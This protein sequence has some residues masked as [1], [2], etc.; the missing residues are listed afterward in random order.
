MTDSYRTLAAHI[1][2][3]PDKTKG[4]RHVAN[5]FPVTD[6]QQ[7]DEA[8]QSARAR[9]PDANHHAFAWRLGRGANDFRYSDDG[10]P[11]GSAGRPMLQQL[12]GRELTDVLAVVSRYFGGTKLGTGGLVRAYGG[13][14]K[15]ALELAE[16][17]EVVPH[18]T[19]RIRHA[20]EDSGAL[21]SVCNQFDVQPTASD[22]GADVTVELSLPQVRADEFA[23]AV[24]DATA[25]RA[26]VEVTDSDRASPLRSPGRGRSAP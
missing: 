21:A 18:A 19:I 14:V 10:E 23:R 26:R 5:L 1:E 24:R 20:Y 13:A 25:A 2:H 17:V 16:I 11:S 22:Y 3:E 12:D 15:E 9:M 6:Q 7:I 4:S 8:L